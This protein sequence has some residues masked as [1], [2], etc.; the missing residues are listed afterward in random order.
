MNAVIIDPDADTLQLVSR[1]LKKQGFR[2]IGRCDDIENTGPILSDQ[3]YSVAFIN[4]DHYQAVP[5]GLFDP[6]FE[7]DPDMRI[8]AYGRDAMIQDAVEAMRVGAIDF[9]SVPFTDTRIESVCQRVMRHA[10]RDEH[11]KTLE[12][13]NQRHR[14][15]L[16]FTSGEPAMREVFDIASR[17]APTDATVLM[18]GESGTGKTVLARGIHDNSNRAGQKFTTVH[19]P[20]LSRELLESSLFGHVKGAFT[21]A[22]RDQ[23]GSVAAGDGGTLFLDEIGEL[24]MEIQPKLLQLL[25]E[26]SYQRIGENKVRHADVRVISATN[27]DLQEEVAKG[28]FRE[29]LYYRLNVVAMSLPPLR[30]R[31]TDTLRIAESMLKHLAAAM[32]TCASHY[33]DASAIFALQNHAWPGNLRELRN[34]IERALILAREPK[35]TASDL[36]LTAG[37]ADDGATDGSPLTLREMEHRYIESV[38]AQTSSLA[39]AARVLDVAPST[40]YRKRKNHASRPVDFLN[41]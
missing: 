38:V 2:H 15:P 40:L 23:W 11:T 12:T 14:T 5:V 8:I 30:E 9:I 24:P 36:G 20:S 1:S 41:V 16:D 29:D 18:L 22:V 6:I 10:A 27:R 19:C 21:G 33:F 25:Q 32:D 7:Q 37:G 31:M 17:V 3:P 35:I 26:K 34:V 39:E 28:R 13:E 4:L